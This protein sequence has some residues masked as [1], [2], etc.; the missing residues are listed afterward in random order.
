[1]NRPDGLD[2]DGC[3][4]VGCM[5][6]RNAECL[7]VCPGIGEPHHAHRAR[8]GERREGCAAGRLRGGL[9]TW[10]IAASDPLL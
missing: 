9:I 8:W 3:V 1:M 2:A 4:E 7:P 5:C 10:L 6:R